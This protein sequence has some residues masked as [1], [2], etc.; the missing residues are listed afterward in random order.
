MGLGPRVPIIGPLAEP[1]RVGLIAQARRIDDDTTSRWEQ[2]FAFEPEN[3]GANRG[4]VD[5]CGSEEK[6]LT[7]SQTIVDYEPYVVWAGDR[8]SAFGWNSR[9]YEARARRLLIA[10]ESKQI[11]EEFWTGEK[12][13]AEG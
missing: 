7:G 6:A 4:I 3:C 5:P 10:C 1:P 12:A 8:C 9:D 2:S 11:E 13:Q